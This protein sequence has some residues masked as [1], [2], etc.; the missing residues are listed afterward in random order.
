MKIGIQ[1][2]TYNS[3]DSF[4][5]L[6]EPWL[7]LKDRYDLKI[8]VGSGQFKIYHD[9]GCENLN[10]PTIQLLES[11]LGQ[12]KIDYLFQPDPDNLLGDHT[13]RDK[14]IPWMREQDIDLMIQLDSDEFY[15]EEEVNNYIEFIEQN[16]DYNYKTVFNNLIGEGKSIDWEKH[17]AWWIKRFGGISHYYYDAH[18]SYLGEGNPIGHKGE[19]NIEYRR[20][21]SLTI[22]KELVNPQHYTW[23]NDENIGGPSHVKEKIEYQKRYY[24]TGECGYVWDENEQKVKTVEEMNNEFDWGNSS[25]S[26]IDLVSREI[27]EGK[28][29]ETI[30][31][32]Q[33]G[34]VVMDLGASTGPFTWSIMGKA[35][36]VIAVEPSKELIPLIKKNTAGYP[37][38]IVNKALAKW[39]GVEI[40]PHVYD[41]ATQYN[42]S[43]VDQNMHYTSKE[44]E[45]TTFKSII[46]EYNLS[47][48]DFIKTDCEGGEYSLF[49]EANMPYLLNNVRNIVGEWHLATPETKV[50]FRY[51]RD[52]YLKQFPKYEVYSVDGVN[53]KWDLWNDHFIEYY[54]EVII[55]I[56]NDA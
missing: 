32:V 48:I 22:P 20:P 42:A 55:H 30:F 7:K 28:C 26:F 17:T 52:K 53:I 41:I 6:I 23:T 14:C 56:S 25:P 54:N 15:T 4:E 39:D 49:T 34:D 46:E 11:M 9:M 44:V 31:P 10:G 47:K 8:W 19:G 36:K 40:I 50:E 18:W 37:V 16:P 24:N 51:F 29:Y 13:T 27:F 45:T 5:K 3:A 33:E 2:I 21:P 12:G 1:I 38:S 43:G 35:S